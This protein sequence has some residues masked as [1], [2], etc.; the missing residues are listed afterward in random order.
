MHPFIIQS[1]ATERTRDRQQSAKHNADASVARAR[2]SRKHQA[3]QATG[4]VR[5]LQARLHLRAS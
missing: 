3:S 4:A 2:R 1:L 5:P